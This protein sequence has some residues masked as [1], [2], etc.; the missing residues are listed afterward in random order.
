M[1]NVQ[2]FLFTNATTK[3][4]VPSSLFVRPRIPNTIQYSPTLCGEWDS[5]VNREDSD[6]LK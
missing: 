2:I 5:D 6:G 3:L 4:V 1:I